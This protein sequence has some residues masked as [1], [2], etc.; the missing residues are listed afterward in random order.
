MTTQTENEEFDI[1]KIPKDQVKELDHDVW[2]RCSEKMY[3]IDLYIRRKV[4]HYRG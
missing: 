4:E 2:L 1:Y 3:D